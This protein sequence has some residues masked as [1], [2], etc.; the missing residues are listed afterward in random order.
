MFIRSKRV[1]IGLTTYYNENLMISLSGVSRFG[2]RCILIIH[3]DNP[4]TKIT[5]RQIRD[6]GYKGKLHIINSSRN[7]G[8]LNSRLAIIDFVKQ[9]RI[10]AKWFIFADDD[11]IL[12]NLD[13][14]KIKSNHFAIIQNM[15]VIRTRLI[16]VLRAIKRPQDVQID[17]ENIYMVRPH[18]GLAGTLVRAVHMMRLGDVLHY[19][20]TGISD[21]IEGLNFRPPIDMIMWSALN[22]VARDSATDVAPIYMDTINYIATD[23][24][25]VSQKYGMLLAPEKNA[26]DKI[27]AIIAKCDNV[28]RTSLADMATTPV[29]SESDR[30]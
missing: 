10:K 20:H 30:Q 13:I 16:D 12:L 5:R 7:I 22:I 14:P 19:A 15:A 8:L 3:N 17:N 21:V 28:I 11:D 29:G 9:H 26:Q 23:L 18:M 27:L 24:D 2:R 25:S 1:I 6:I 4:E